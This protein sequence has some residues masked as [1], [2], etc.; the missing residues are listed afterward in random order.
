MV[1]PMEVDGGGAKNGPV[2]GRV[3][4]GKG[5]ALPEAAV[6]DHLLTAPWVEKYR[7]K[8]LADVAA[9]KDI[10]NTS[11]L[12]MTSNA[13]AHSSNTSAHSNSALPTH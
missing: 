13:P 5:P 8:T 1:D 7:P 11:E 2:P 3:D 10:V 4:K 12:T 9:H 6:Q